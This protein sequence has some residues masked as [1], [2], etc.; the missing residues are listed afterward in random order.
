MYN[1]IIIVIIT[2]ISLIY[3][4]ITIR[5]IKNTIQREKTEITDLVTRYNNNLHE[6]DEN[7]DNGVQIIREQCPECEV[8]Q[9]IDTTYWVS[10]EDLTYLVQRDISNYEFDISDDSTVFRK[11]T[12]SD[13]GFEI[14]GDESLF[15]INKNISVNGHNLVEGDYIVNGNI[16]VNAWD[17]MIAP[18]YV[19]FNNDDELENLRNRGWYIC[20]GTNGTPNLQGRFIW[21]GGIYDNA[22]LNGMVD[23]NGNTDT[24]YK[25]F[26]ATGGEANHTLI[27]DEIPSHKHDVSTNPAGSHN[28]QM[29]VYS[30]FY[31]GDHRHPYAKGSDCTNKSRYTSENQMTH[32][33][34]H[35]HGI[36]ET[37]KGGNLPHNN[38]PP[39][40][41]LAY[42]MYI[43]NLIESSVRNTF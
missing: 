10:K 43:P 31:N 39:Y 16:I 38:L 20:D 36:S 19:N 42:F 7:E 30:C 32:S 15:E 13:L 26:E 24:N 8:C 28:H 22:S 12:G 5:N 33:E 3:N 6:Q 11:T 14:S 17:K 25:R 41:V 9:N 34:N 1:L 21:G 37:N 18:F 27:L 4:F 40:Y 2:L 35:V 23:K 29:V